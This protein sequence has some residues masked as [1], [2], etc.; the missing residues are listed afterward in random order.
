MTPDEEIFCEFTR[1][2]VVLEERR[3]RGLRAVSLAWENKGYSLKF[4]SEVVQAEFDHLTIQGT[5][6]K[7]AISNPVRLEI[8]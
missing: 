3:R 2:P 5:K 6:S 7:R 1:L 8:R 4:I